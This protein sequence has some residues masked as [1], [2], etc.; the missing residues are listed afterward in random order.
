MVRWSRYV[1]RIG[2]KKYI[3]FFVENPE[4]RRPFGRRKCTYENIQIM[5]ADY[6]LFD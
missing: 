5:D 4:G 3:F 2:D 6:I 1:A